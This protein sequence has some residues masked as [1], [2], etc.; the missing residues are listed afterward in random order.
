MNDA[1]QASRG[2]CASTTTEPRTGSAPLDSAL[3]VKAAAALLGVSPSPVYLLCAWAKIRHERHGL[4]RGVIRIPVEAIGE[5]RTRAT[6]A[7]TVTAS[8]PPPARVELSHIRL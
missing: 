3:K 4:G 6:V 5:Y 1:G 7:G 8:P 2:T